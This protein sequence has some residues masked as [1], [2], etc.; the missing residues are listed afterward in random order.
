MTETILFE[1]WSLAHWKLFV[2]WWLG[3]GAYPSFTDWLK[4]CVKGLGLKLKVIGI[5]IFQPFL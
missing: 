3:F 1:I 5:E 2:I 4:Y